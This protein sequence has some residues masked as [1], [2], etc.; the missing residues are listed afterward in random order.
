MPALEEAMGADAK[1]FFALQRWAE[2]LDDQTPFSFS[3]H[4]QISIRTI[5]ADCM[6]LCE[7]FRAKPKF[8]LS[9][10]MSALRRLD[11]NSRLNRFIEKPQ[12][13]EVKTSI[14]RID[15][16]VKKYNSKSHENRTEYLQGVIDDIEYNLKRISQE[17]EG[18]YQGLIIE[19]LER[20]LTSQYKNRNELTRLDDALV[21]AAGEIVRMGRNAFESF[22]Y[23]QKAMAE[24]LQSQSV[25]FEASFMAAV[26]ELLY[27]PRRQ[28]FVAVVLDRTRSIREAS[29]PSNLRFKTLSTRGCI[30]WPRSAAASK[31]NDQ[32]LEAFAI[33]HW[34]PEGA[35]RRKKSCSVDCIVKIV[36][37][38]A[39][40]QNDARIEA[41][42]AAELLVDLVNSGSRTK[43]IGVKR[44]VMVFDPLHQR[45]QERRDN[46]KHWNDARPLGVRDPEPLSKSLRFVTRAR[47]ERSSA[48]S[49]LFYW[50]A[51]ENVFSEYENAA[52]KVM[53]IAPDAMARAAIRDAVTY[54]RQLVYTQDSVLAARGGGARL[55]DR[56]N[57]TGSIKYTDMTEFL[58]TSDDPWADLGQAKA[59]LYVSFRLDELARIARSN[60]ALKEWEGLVVRRTQWVLERALHQRNQAVHSAQSD[61]NGERPLSAACREIVDSVFEVTAL[62]LNSSTMEPSAALDSFREDMKLLRRSWMEQD[63]RAIFRSPVILGY[64]EQVTGN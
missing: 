25:S 57:S 51:L 59:T 32:K 22:L 55:S 11:A 56:V 19:E 26:K 54:S 49:V 53:A 58:T 64:E 52:A 47:H 61:V 17:L 36:E 20:R 33:K 35:P 3:V 60:T 16:H 12:M 6:E 40:D 41:L 31:T 27:R 23:V 30:T 24:Q 7:G 38:E 45:A 42:R 43:S 21:K 29:L 34:Y 8:A 46:Q 48:M 15:G 2:L 18:G 39:W 44:K 28:F 1:A 4:S 14:R 10:L 62:R 37:V 50:I 63:C 5:V 9:H 13:A